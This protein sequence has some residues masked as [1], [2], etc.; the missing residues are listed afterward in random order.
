M[1]PWFVR[2]TPVS[3]RPIVGDSITFEQQTQDKVLMKCIGNWTYQTF[4]PDAELDAAADK[5][6]LFDTRYRAASR[7]YVVSHTEDVLLKP[8]AKPNMGDFVEGKLCALAKDFANVT[9]TIEEILPPAQETTAAGNARAE[10]INTQGY[11]ARWNAFKTTTADHGLD[12]NK[13]WEAFERREGKRTTEQV[14]IDGLRGTGDPLD[15]AAADLLAQRARNQGQQNQSPK[16]G[17]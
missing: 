11:L 16:G 10:L 17:E 14:I 8:D 3:M 5:K 7:E 1:L 6:Q 12:P 15:A 4:D 2:V 9:V 13:L